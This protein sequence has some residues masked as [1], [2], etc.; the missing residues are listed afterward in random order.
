MDLVLFRSSSYVE[1]ASI[2]LWRVPLRHRSVR[3]AVICG[4]IYGQQ[5]QPVSTIGRQIGE[6]VPIS[7]HL[8]RYLITSQSSKKWGD[9]HLIS[10][11]HCR[12]S[13]K[14]MAKGGNVTNVR[15]AFLTYPRK[16][17]RHSKSNFPTTLHIQN[18]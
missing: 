4:N 12:M 5:Q 18:E 9:A 3:Q 11:V 7:L 1:D 15:N 13:L 14:A 6:S 8:L 16:V 10:N 2:W 17:Y